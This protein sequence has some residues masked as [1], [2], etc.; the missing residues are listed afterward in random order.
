MKHPPD[1]DGSGSSR[2]PVL[3][4]IISGNIL[5]LEMKS[6][7]SS[8]RRAQSVAILKR[9]LDIDCLSRCPILLRIIPGNRSIGIR[10][11][12]IRFYYLV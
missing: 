3:P 8:I 7:D 1:V 12:I 4:R 9:P 11:E 6:S 2:C 5:E 10:N